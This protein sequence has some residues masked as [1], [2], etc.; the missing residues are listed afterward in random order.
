MKRPVAWRGQ[1]IVSTCAVVGLLTATA[2]KPVT[3][4]AAEKRALVSERPNESGAFSANVLP[5]WRKFPLA[6]GHTRPIPANGCEG[7]SVPVSIT[8]V[9]G[10]KWIDPDTPPQQT[11]LLAWIENLSP[12]PTIATEKLPSFRPRT[13]AAYA[14]IADMDPVS[15]KTRWQIL[16]FRLGAD[17]VGR[18]VAAGIFK[19][20][21]RYIPDPARESEADFK[22]CGPQIANGLTPE[23]T[24]QNVLTDSARTPRPRP[25][26]GGWIDCNS[27]CCT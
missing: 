23:R 24:S 15:G 5:T 11:Q 27:G 19:V 10:S 13:E 8:A 26:I 22:A 4:G 16:E 7:C 3:R 17:P 1:V 2:L 25:P 12:L 6:L 20:C 9:Q 18:V 21:H 14:E